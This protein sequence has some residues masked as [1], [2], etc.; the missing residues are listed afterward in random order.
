MLAVNAALPVKTVPE[1]ID[2]A[3]KNP[4]KLSYGSAGIGSGHHIAGELLK[5]RT[6]IDMVHVPYRGGAPAIQDLIAGNIQISFGTPPA[7]LPHHAAGT[8]RIIALAEA[9]RHPDLPGIPTIDETVPGVV[10]NTWLGLFAPAG[11]PR[12]IV[13]RLNKAMV[14]ALKLSD[15]AAKFKLQGLTP[16]SSTPD[17]LDALAKAELEAWGRIIPAIGIQPE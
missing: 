2:Y 4:R 1:L 15:V 17:E 11:T 5:Q 6:G 10:T 13:D 12:P 3:R 8:I 14:A 9:K 7:V 16:R